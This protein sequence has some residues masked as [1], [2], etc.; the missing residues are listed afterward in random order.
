MTRSPHGVG[1]LARAAVGRPA[2]PRGGERPV[3]DVL[4]GPGVR[5][6]RPAA[7]R[8]HRA[9]GQRG[10]GQDV[11]DRRAGR[12][13]RGRGHAAGATAAGHLHPDRH[14]RAARARA[15][16]AAQRRAGAARRLAGMA[17]RRPRAGPAR[18]RPPRRGERAAA[19]PAPGRVASF[20]A[21]TIATTH[22]FCQEVLDG[23][24]IAGDLEPDVTFVEDLCDLA[25][26]VIDD[27][28][29]RRFSPC[30][31]PGLRARRGGRDRPGGDR[32]PG[33][34][35]SSPAT[36]RCPRCAAGWPQASGRSSS[37]ASGGLRVM[38]YDDL[39]IRLDT[40][41]RR[42]RR[43]GRGRGSW[44]PLRRRARR[45]VPGHRSRRS[46]RSCAAP[47]PTPAST[48]VLIAD[49]KQAIYAF[50]GAD[51]YAYLEAAQAAGSGHAARQLAQRPGADRRPRRAALG[52]QARPPRIAYRQ[53]RASAAHARAAADRAR[54]RAAPLRFRVLRRDHPDAVR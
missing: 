23:L 22:G 27:L 8:R 51:V 37:A 38:T 30:G 29:V 40:T 25:D 47:S 18:R 43:A 34:D 10:N 15:R 6:L 36:R 9:R 52:G 26:D 48:L 46:G 28:Y 4:R 45:R 35:R 17:R 21:A 33:R 49:P 16:A 44:P 13:L 42:P 31:L 7:H 41:L 24:G 50:R 39:V 19:T 2:R 1:R 32:Q 53:V 11:H 3:S 12:A 5:C 54:R 20:D 14:R